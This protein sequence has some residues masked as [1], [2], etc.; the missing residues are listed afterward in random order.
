MR[1]VLAVMLALA[2][3]LGVL[4]AGRAEHGPGNPPTPV[5]YGQR[6]GTSPRE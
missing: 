5:Q 4:A 2:T 3:V 6:R 1:T